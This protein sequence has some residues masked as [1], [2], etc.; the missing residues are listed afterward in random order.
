MQSQGFTLWLPFPD[1]KRTIPHQLFVLQMPTVS[2]WDVCRSKA[3]KWNRL[4]RA[5]RVATDRTEGRRAGSGRDAEAKPA[6]PRR[7]S[8]PRRPWSEKDGRGAPQFGPRR[9]TR[10]DS[11][12]WSAGFRETLTVC[13]WAPL[14]SSRDLNVRSW[15]R[16]KCVRVQWKKEIKEVA[17]WM[18]CQQ[19][20]CG[21][22]AG[23]WSDVA[24]QWSIWSGSYSDVTWPRIIFGFGDWRG[25][26]ASAKV[27]QTLS[28]LPGK[29]TLS[30][31]KRAAG[32]TLKARKTL[33][34]W[35]R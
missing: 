11:H 15:T 35:Q 26:M 20:Y 33:F 16:V 30:V 4:V 14:F 31:A 1:T 29:D 23:L 34:Y 18:W 22:P 25:R 8:V 19:V 21:R 3:L 12:S 5:R 7:P 6:S 27:S 9:R 24:T 2:I 32:T 10:V 13:D 17:T 28:C